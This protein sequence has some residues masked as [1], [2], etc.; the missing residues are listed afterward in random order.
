MF[1]SLRL[2]T[3]VIFVLINILLIVL[4][5]RFSYLFVRNL[6]LEQFRE[7][8]SIALRVAEARIDRP[9]LRF[10]SPD[11]P[12]LARTYVANTLAQLDT[13]LQVKNIFIFNRKGQVLSALHTHDAQTALLINKQTINDL[14]PGQHLISEPF[15]ADDGQ[16]YLWA[17][18]RLSADLFIGLRENAQRL[19]QINRLSGQFLLF[20]LLGMVLTFLA[21]L[22]IARSV[23][24]PLRKIIRFSN[25]I[26]R[27][28]F[29]APT[30][31][32]KIKEMK[33][34]ASALSQMRD[35]LA[36]R[37][38]EKEQMLAQIAHELRNPLGGIELLAD[39]IRDDLP[40]NHDDIQYLNRIS[41]EVGHLK[42]Q[43]NQFLHYSR[44]R[45]SQRTMVR[46]AKLINELRE[47]Y[48]PVLREKQAE[49]R[50]EFRQPFILFDREHLRQIL[51]NLISNSLQALNGKEGIITIRSHNDTLEVEDNGPGIAKSEREKIFRPFFT[52][53][54]DGIGLGLTICKKLCTLNGASV[55]VSEGAKGG[56]LFII[57]LNSK[58]GEA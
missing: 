35:A 56:A 19:A 9:F 21:A 17:F 54:T 51:N 15:K 13:L 14:Q 7:Q 46:L 4:L 37:D 43:I 27:G 55:T 3:I 49:L 8:V 47:Y 26:G 40:A 52:S 25:R 24:A 10:L 18:N 28:D 39:L 32:F 29:T 42:K 58:D 5:A 41:D 53:K 12:S 31:D 22:F 50:T 2:R 23:H 34:L 16:W 38:R 6:Y 57:K 45:P 33:Q 44:P 11:E 48:A 36:Q 1:N 30:P 20:G